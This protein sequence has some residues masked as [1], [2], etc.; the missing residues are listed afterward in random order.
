MK[1]LLIATACVA[2]L[3]ALATSFAVAE[4]S[5]GAAATSTTTAAAPAQPEMQL[6]P[7][8]TAE[9]MQ[10]IM[11]AATPGKNHELLVKEA[12]VWRGKNSLVMFPGAEPIVTESKSTITP[13]LDGRF[14]RCEMEGE[15]P[16]MGMFKGEGIYGYDN[17]SQKFVAVWF[18]N[19]GTGLMNGSVFGR[20]AGTTAGQ[21][22]AQ[23]P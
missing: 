19:M 10:A 9:D 20:I 23:S 18:D 6:P 2:S 22:A 16:G 15:M 12:G 14:V 11:E 3:A 21:R 13:M 4:S 5:G 7:G 8:W 17:V 1:K